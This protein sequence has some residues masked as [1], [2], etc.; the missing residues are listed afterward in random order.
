MYI[1]YNK[2]TFE[3]Y[4]ILLFIKNIAVINHKSNFIH[5]EP[6]SLITRVHQRLDARDNL[7]T[8]PGVRCLLNDLKFI[9]I[10]DF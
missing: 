6:S 3:R 10:R 8:G 2:I 7:V 9:S 1:Y 4:E 5:Y